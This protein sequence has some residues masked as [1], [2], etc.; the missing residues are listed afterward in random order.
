MSVR[1]AVAVSSPIGSRLIQ[2]SPNRVF[3]PVGG[4]YL[5]RMG[6]LADIFNRILTPLYGSQDKAIRQI[7]ESEDRKC[8]LLY[9]DDTPVGVLVFKTVLSDEFADFG[10]R[11]SI[12]IKSLF[13]DQSIQNS[14]RGLGSAL[15]SKVQ[16]EADKLGLGHE[17]IHVTV[18]ETK[19]ESLMFFKKKGFEIMHAWKDRYVQGVTEFLLSCP[20]IIQER[21][22]RQAEILAQRLDQVSIAAGSSGHAPEL[23]HVIHDAHLDDVHALKRLANGNFV[24][25][26]K[27]NC[28]Y[29]WNRSGQRVTVV[30]EVE[31]T[32]QSERN[33]VTAVEVLNDDYWLSGERNGRISLWKTNGDYVRDIGLKL[34]RRGEY[35]SHEYNARRVNCLAAS[36]SRSPSFFVGFP[37]M[38]DEFNFIEGRT[39]T[40]TKA[41]ENDWVYCVRPLDERKILTVTGCT[42]DLWGKEERGWE[43]IDNIVPEGKKV[44]GLGNKWQ[45]AFISSLVPLVSD[46]NHFGISL[47]NG[48]VKVVDITRK[49]TVKEWREHTG[50]VWTVENIAQNLFASSGDDRSIKLWDL[51]EPSSVHTIADHV[52]GVTSMLSLDE[53]LLVAGTCPENAFKRSQ[54]AEIRFYDI[55]RG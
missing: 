14:G 30:D 22:Q 38:F 21:G 34:P 43:K 12:E 8:F 32:N 49:V 46:P 29:I 52:G 31:P 24:S 15:V 26:S 53:N 40:C 20:T 3:Y 1:Q 45:R 11:R 2:H 16:E 33:W 23:V 55:R 7:Q 27:D 44:K 39:E 37:T 50:R 35:V 48:S 10:V 51:R 54:A 4:Q 28:L 13:V 6:V 9:E 18:S 47:F 19:E 17:G 42:V 41:A 5:E 25:G 36:L